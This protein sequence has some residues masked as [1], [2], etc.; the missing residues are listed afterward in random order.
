MS[1]LLSS[2]EALGKGFD[3]LFNHFEVNRRNQVEVIRK[4][5]RS[6]ETI[7]SKS[8]PWVWW[9]KQWAFWAFFTWK[10]GKVQFGHDGEYSV[11]TESIE[12]E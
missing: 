3:K 7:K 6:S 9:V 10:G 4:G 12:I 1:R 11:M 5:A 2:K 8:G